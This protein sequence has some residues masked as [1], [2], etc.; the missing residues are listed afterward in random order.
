MTMRKQEEQDNLVGLHLWP[1]LSG[2]SSSTFTFVF[3]CGQAA[4]QTTVQLALRANALL[5]SP[6][7]TIFPANR[8]TRSDTGTSP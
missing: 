8:I 7:S 5:Q 6:P 2:F 3:L 1:L 4:R